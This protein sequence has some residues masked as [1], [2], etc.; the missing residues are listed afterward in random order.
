MSQWVYKVVCPICKNPLSKDNKKIGIYQCK[1]TGR[2]RKVVQDAELTDDEDQKSTQ[3]T[4]NNDSIQESLA[5]P[6][7][8]D[9]DVEKEEEFPKIVNNTPG[10]FLKMDGINGRFVQWRYMTLEIKKLPKK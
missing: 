7:I 4:E 3:K 2:G 5:N 10:G 9:Y 1:L 8:D 6:N